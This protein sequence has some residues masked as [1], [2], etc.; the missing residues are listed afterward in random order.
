[1]TDQVL[2]LATIKLA[3]HSTEADLLTASKTFQEEFLN[4]QDGFIRRDMVRKGDG[5]FL[6]VILWE[7]RAQADAVF[8]RAQTSEAAGAYFGHMLMDADDMED[9]VEHCVLV[10]SFGTR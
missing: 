6:D 5:T 4:N 9:G 1:M 10:G 7:S 3:P 2:E 8:E